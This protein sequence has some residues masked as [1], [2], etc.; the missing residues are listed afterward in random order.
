MSITS[1]CYKQGSWGYH[2][3]ECFLTAALINIAFVG[4]L[5]IVSLAV[6][7]AGTLG[8]EQRQQGGVRVIQQNHFKYGVREPEPSDD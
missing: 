4:R 8:G 1:C 6:E 7:S 3:D 2:G 5:C